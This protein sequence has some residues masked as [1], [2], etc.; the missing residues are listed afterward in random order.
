MYTFFVLIKFLKISHDNILLRSKL[1]SQDVTERLDALKSIENLLAKLPSD[2][3][4][5]I[6]SKRL[7]IPR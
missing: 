7:F 6:E 1:T 4:N 2:H 3:L 5:S